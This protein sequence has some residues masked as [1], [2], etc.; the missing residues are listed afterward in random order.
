M[1]LLD[2]KNLFDNSVR[3][4]T[5]SMQETIRR[6]LNRLDDDDYAMNDHLA[7]SLR[8][9]L[10]EGSDADECIE[11]LERM[12]KALQQVEDFEEWSHE[13]F[14]NRDWEAPKLATLLMAMVAGFR[15]EQLAK[16][17]IEVQNMTRELLRL[18][19]KKPNG[20]EF[21][22][23]LEIFMDRLKETAEENGIDLQWSDTCSLPLTYLTAWFEHRYWN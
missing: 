22:K 4:V 12:R 3:C 10:N 11:A 18:A 20:G 23:L 2:V 13:H 17:A 15:N 19:S 5:L 8:S 9:Q 1:D 7:E 21:A 14:S 16:C 6:Q